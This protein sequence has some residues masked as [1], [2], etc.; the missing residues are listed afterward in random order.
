M[1]A[2]VANSVSLL[3]ARAHTSSQQ[4]SDET[5][6]RPPKH[7]AHCLA[8]GWTKLPKMTIRDSV[9]N[10]SRLSKFYIA[11]SILEKYLL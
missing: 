7:T 8:S 10:L 6:H 9:R 4:G 3:G 1:C 5:Q 11:F 2:T